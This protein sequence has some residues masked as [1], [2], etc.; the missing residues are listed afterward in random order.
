[1][2]IRSLRVLACLYALAAAAG[3]RSPYYADRGTAVGALGGAGVGALVGSASGDAGAGALIGAGV[4]ALTGNVVGAALDDI[5]AR[6]RAE[7]AAQH[8][9]AGRG[10]SRHARRGRGDEPRGRRSALIVNYINTSG[11]AQPI[12]AQDVIYLHAARRAAGR[13]SGDADAAR[14]PGAADGRWSRHRSPVFV[15]EVTTARRPT[16][17]RRHHCY[18]YRGPRVG[19]GVSFSS[20]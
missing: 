3:C 1:M 19:W 15:E 4:G 11:V 2:T 12:L 10:R 13:D 20:H 9:P 17:V 7:I 16:T 5:E 6:N 8:G 18:H 14:R